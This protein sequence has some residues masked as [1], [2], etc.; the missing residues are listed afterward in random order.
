MKNICEGK[1][2]QR[3]KKH[4]RNS[5][6][7]TTAFVNTNTVV[8]TIGTKNY[9]SNWS[10]LASIYFF[11][12]NNGNTR[13]TTPE[14]RLGVFIVNLEQISDVILVFPLLTLN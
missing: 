5:N 14:R 7:P 9:S 13:T 6:F 4:L 8:T 1:N 12:V 11:K 3:L 2:Y 10:S